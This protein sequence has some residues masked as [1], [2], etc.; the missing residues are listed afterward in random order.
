MVC[1]ATVQ[2]LL[3][4]LCRRSYG[5]PGEAIARAPFC[6][7]LGDAARIMLFSL[8]DA[9]GETLGKGMEVVRT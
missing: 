2:S 8:G 7:T 1:W 9:T 4:A 5:A 6:G 3:P